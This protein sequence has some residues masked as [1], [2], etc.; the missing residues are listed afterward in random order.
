VTHRSTAFLIVSSHADNDA[1]RFIDQ[2]PPAGID[3][4]WDP[5]YQPSVRTYMYISSHTCQ[6][7]SWIDTVDYCGQLG[8]WFP[9]VCNTHPAFVGMQAALLIVYVWWGMLRPCTALHRWHHTCI[10]AQA[11]GTFVCLIRGVSRSSLAYISV[12]FLSVDLLPVFCHIVVLQ[13]DFA[14]FSVSGKEHSSIMCVC[15]TF[16]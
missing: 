5:P 8:L 16:A 1:K 7:F 15:V 3:W 12:Q 10:N 2:L 4:A 14:G 11:G 9:A 6:K 13:G